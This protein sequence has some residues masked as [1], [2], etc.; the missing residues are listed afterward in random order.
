MKNETEAQISYFG[1]NCARESP[2]ARA[3]WLLIGQNSTRTAVAL[4]GDEKVF[5][6]VPI[7]IHPFDV[8]HCAL[9]L[10]FIYK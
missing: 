2:C 1:P 8:K 3:L 9:V 5:E 10:S 7:E 4:T 6:T